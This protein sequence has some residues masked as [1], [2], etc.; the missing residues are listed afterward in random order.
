MNDAIVLE[1]PYKIRLYAL[2]CL[3]YCLKLEKVGIKFKGGSRYAYVKRTYGFK[4]S[5][6]SV[7]DQLK[8]Y[9]A[10]YTKANSQLFN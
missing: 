2:H 9:I 4:G 5:K 6:Q 8:K 7:L 3:V 1:T 10:D